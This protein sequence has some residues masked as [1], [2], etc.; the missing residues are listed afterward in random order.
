ML[1]F[2]HQ[3]S[4]LNIS[5]NFFSLPPST[6][7]IK[8]SVV[9]CAHHH[10]WL[11]LRLELHSSELEKKPGNQHIMHHTAH[12]ARWKKCKKLNLHRIILFKRFFIQTSSHGCIEHSVSVFAY[13]EHCPTTSSF[14][15]AKSNILI[16]SLMTFITCIILFFAASYFHSLLHK[17][18]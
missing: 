13:S 15:S 4:Y 17:C 12:C 6:L 16:Q 2:M 3:V 11:T 1:Y 5:R 14:N 7:I 18:H 10:K 9:R 8:R